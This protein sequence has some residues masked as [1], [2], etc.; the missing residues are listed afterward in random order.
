MKVSKLPQLFKNLNILE[1]DNRNATFGAFQMN[2][3]KLAP[4]WK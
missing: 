3:K 4:K 1:V 2:V